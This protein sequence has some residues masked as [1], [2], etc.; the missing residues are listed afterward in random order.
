MNVKL[1]M[2]VAFKIKLMSLWMFF[3]N[4]SYH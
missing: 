4:Y 2:D 1:N 3:I